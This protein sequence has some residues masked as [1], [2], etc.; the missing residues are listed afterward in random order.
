MDKVRTLM[1]A[2]TALAIMMS[3]SAFARDK[4]H[5]NV[6]IPEAVQVGSSRL[7][8]GEYTME[9]NEKGSTA[10]VNF[11]QHGKSVT[12]A[13]AKVVNLGHPAKSDSVTMMAAVGTA[14]NLE[15]IEFH[16]QKE[17]FSFK[18]IPKGE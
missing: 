9:W 10:E 1:L 4:N 7:A 14:G 8:P 16:G 2:V 15:Q 3:V 17:A 13:S 18:E 6:V 11:F 12:Q 5:H